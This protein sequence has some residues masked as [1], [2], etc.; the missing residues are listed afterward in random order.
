MHEFS[1]YEYVVPRRTEGKWILLRA[2][3]IFLY[4]CFV[5][6]WLIFGL[7]T[8]I[9]VPLL[10]FIPVTL[11]MLVFATW[12][13][14]SVEYEYSITSGVL[15]F[16]EIYGRHSRKKRLEFPLRDAVRIAPLSNAEEHAR[17][18][19]YRPEREFS[20]VSS[21]HAP[22]IYF[23]LFEYEDKHEKE[24]RRAIFY[25]EA[26]ERALQICRFYNPSST[27]LE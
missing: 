11:W 8:R 4:I 27:I 13:Y 26:T 1:T 18:T 20:A 19:A 2:G 16:T 9:L 12:R 15:T 10:A 17:G 5:A 25:F 7:L 22:H 24:K 3:L 6:A 21:F 14:V 23:V